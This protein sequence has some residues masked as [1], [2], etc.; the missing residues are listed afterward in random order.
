MIKVHLSLVKLASGIVLH[1]DDN[2][3]IN[4]ISLK[5]SRGYPRVSKVMW[6]CFT[7]EAQGHILNKNPLILS[8]LE[9]ELL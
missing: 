2:Y 6:V 5:F 3:K 7:K 1:R 9:I 8:S 4:S